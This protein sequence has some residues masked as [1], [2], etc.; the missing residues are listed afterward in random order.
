M[1]VKLADDTFPTFYWEKVGPSDQNWACVKLDEHE[2]QAP[3]THPSDAVFRYRHPYTGKQT[4][5]IFDYK[6][7][8][9]KSIS[10]SAMGKATVQLGFALDCAMVSAGW[11]GLYLQD[12]DYDLQG[13]LFVYNHD[14]N[15]KRNLSKQIYRNINS[16]FPESWAKLQKQHE[17]WVIDPDTIVFLNSA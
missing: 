4:Y 10:V 8:A 13:G 11:Q 15:Y 2:R 17:I 12:D 1:A 16:N 6:S 5:I 7:L 14:N 9:D 3:K